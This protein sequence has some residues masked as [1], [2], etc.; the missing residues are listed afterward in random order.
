MAPGG[1]PGAQRARNATWEPYFALPGASKIASWGRLGAS[2]VAPGASW[3][4][5]GL[6][7]G[8]PGSSF[9]RFWDIF[10]TA[11]LKS[12]KFNDFYSFLEAVVR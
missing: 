6:H 10:F 12:E 2:W 9:W 7:F 3:V 4:A 11:P 1:P 5:P 8:L